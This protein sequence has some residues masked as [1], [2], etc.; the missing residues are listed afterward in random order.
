MPTYKGIQIDVISQ[1]ELQRHPE[2]NHPNSSQSTLR[3]S[4]STE[5][6][7]DGDL[8]E[9]HHNTFHSSKSDQLLG[10]QSTCAVYIPS[11]P[12]TYLTESPSRSLTT[13]QARDSGFATSLRK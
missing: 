7:N 9:G 8:L 13:T 6:L 1:W 10:R 11:V 3:A 12:G 2:F 5:A 4:E